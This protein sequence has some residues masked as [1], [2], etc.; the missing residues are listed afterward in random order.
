LN[1]LKKY[2][3][4][5]VQL[6]QLYNLYKS[7][8]KEPPE[9]FGCI[10]IQMARSELGLGKLEQASE[11]INKAI[12]IFLTD[13]RRNPK[14]A[15]Y[16]ED[17]DLAASYVVQGDILFAENKIK[18]AINFYNKAYSI[19]YYL[20]RD[21]RKNVAQVS[22][23]YSQGAKASCKARNLFSYKFFGKAQVK[24]FGINH[25]NT[26]SMF[27]YCKKYNMGPLKDKNLL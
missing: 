16:S 14:D 4:A 10:Y 26:V 24:E 1:Y 8:K 3:R 15:D 19:Y 25:P 22:Y 9:I 2:Q 23:L 5:H 12:S 27:E 21:N 17:P 11:H 20:Y 18:E 6:K 13:E 7:Y